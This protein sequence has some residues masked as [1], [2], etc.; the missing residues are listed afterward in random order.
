M[1]E[2]L[3][4]DRAAILADYLRTNEVNLPK[5]RA[6]RL[7]AA[8]HG[9]AFAESVYRAY[10]ADERYLRAAWEA[11]GSGDPAERL[12]IPAGGLEAFRRTV[13]EPA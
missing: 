8:A 4:V 7:Q 10:L 13:L 11:M 5:A 3:G 2:A 12:G 6:L 1:L 9:E